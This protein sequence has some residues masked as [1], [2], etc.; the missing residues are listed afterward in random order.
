M[1]NRECESNLCTGC[2]IYHSIQKSTKQPIRY[3][4][5]FSYVMGTLTQ[6]SSTISPANLIKHFP[7]TIRLRH[8]ILLSILEMYTIGMTEAKREE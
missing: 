5:M 7:K 1:K 6:N 8:S 2:R 3:E 4:S